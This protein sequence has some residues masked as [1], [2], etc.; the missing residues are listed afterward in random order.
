MKPTI[1][2]QH[3]LTNRLQSILLLAT[4]AAFSALLG[5]VLWGKDGLY[6]LIIICVILYLLTP[7]IT[8]QII[9]KLYRGHQLNPA[10]IPDLHQSLLVLSQRCGLTTAPK[11]YYIPS[12]M[13]NA[14]AVGQADNAGIAVT[15]G[16]LRALNLREMVN[17]LAHEISHIGNNDMR[18]MAIA[19]MFSR[20]TSALSFAGQV[21]LLIN[22][23][24]IMLGAISFNWLA[25]LLLV[26][27]PVVST[28]AQLGLSRIREY[29]ADLNAIRLTGDPD[30]L[31]SAL[32]KIDSIQGGWIKRIFLPGRGIPEPSL[33]R[34]HPPTAERVR[35][36]QRLKDSEELNN[37]VSESGSSRL[38]HELDNQHVKRKPRWHIGGI[39]H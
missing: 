27:A 39:W 24:L 29:D 10:Q 19:D 4:M 25:V 18:V 9:I 15:D 14:F 37:L 6:I 5:W 16:L 13:I 38:S 26:F 8:P 33:L 36:L 11:I 35:R 12:S 32:I 34:T 2:H 21:L 17:V 1:W 30:G 23:P 31:S 22:L 28:L 3:A 20:V 7:G